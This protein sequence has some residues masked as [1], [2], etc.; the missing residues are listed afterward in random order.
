MTMGSKVPAGEVH[1]PEAPVVDLT[2]L[3]GAALAEVAQAEAGNTCLIFSHS[4]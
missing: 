4:I 2:D 1:H 3:A